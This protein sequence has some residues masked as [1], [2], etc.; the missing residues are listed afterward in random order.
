MKGY[1]AHTIGRRKT[2]V[3]RVF[4][5]KGS[6]QI[7]V[8][9]QD[10]ADYFDRE[11]LNYIVKQPL[12][13]IEAEE[14]YDIKINVVGGGKAGQAGACRH[15]ISRALCE[16]DEEARSQ[17]KPLGFLTRDARKVERKKPGR[18]KARKRPQFSKR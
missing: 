12:I 1:D 10:L 4:L 16:I 7:T 18:H 14:D 6:G 17:I 5:K 15:G 2:S 9:G 8:N 11:T 3:A 13:A